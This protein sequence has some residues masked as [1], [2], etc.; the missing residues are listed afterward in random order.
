[1]EQLA[2]EGGVLW[3]DRNASC[4]TKAASSK[5]AARDSANQ[6]VVTI[7]GFEMTSSSFVMYTFSISVLIQ[8]LAMISFSSF[9]DHGMPT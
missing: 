9:A 7:L 3:S 5:L 4:V 1:M 2:R 6:C 8:A